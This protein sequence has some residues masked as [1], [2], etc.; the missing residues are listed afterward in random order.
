MLINDFALSTVHSDFV[1]R[2]NILTRFFV[3]WYIDVPSLDITV[4]KESV[5]VHKRIVL[6][7]ITAKK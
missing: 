6:T 7:T 2:D 4:L 1:K 5:T 3:N